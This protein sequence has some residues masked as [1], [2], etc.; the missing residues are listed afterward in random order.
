MKFLFLIN[1]LL[2][3][4]EIEFC[5]IKIDNH[6]FQI[7]KNEITYSQYVKYLNQ[8]RFQDSLTIN[9][10]KIFG[11]FKNK[12]IIKNNY[13]PYFYNL[14]TSCTKIDEPSICMNNGEFYLNNGRFKNHAINFVTWFGANKFADYYNYNIPLKHEWEVAAKLDTLSLENMIGG[15]SEWVTD[16]WVPNSHYS[17]RIIKGG[18]TKQPNNKKFLNADSIQANFP[19]HASKF[20]GFRV[21]I[22]Y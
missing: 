4:G 19:S 21:I 13:V 20:V 8:A 17:H 18:S 15:V 22:R 14:D 10:N 7:S 1:I 12:D 6:N 16:L 5:K 9:E 3:A 11:Y 2:F